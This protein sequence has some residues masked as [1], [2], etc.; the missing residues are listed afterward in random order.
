MT[1]NELIDN[2]LQILRN[3]G[4]AESEHI[5]RYQIQQWIIYYRAMLLKQD[6]DKGRDVNPLYITTIEPMH[7]DQVTDTGGQI[8]H[9]GSQEL[10]KLIDFNFRPGVI[11]VRDMYGNLIQLSTRSRSNYQKYAKYA[12]K[13]Y[14][15]YVKDNKIYVEGDNNQLEYISVD[16]IAEDPT[17][18]KACFNPDDDFPIPAAQIPTIVQMIMTKEL[19]YMMAMPTDVTNDSRDDTQNIPQK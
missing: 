10:P 15:A 9:V 5:S 4:V 18:L 7:L 8:R 6:I 2:V 17:E 19:S 13:D 14:I 3:N 12:C 1:L 11:A 16:V